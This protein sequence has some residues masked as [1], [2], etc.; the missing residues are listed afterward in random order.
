[1]ANLLWVVLALL[2][3]AGLF[4]LANA[5]EP[6]WCSPDGL[7]F[8]CRV[9]EI[10]ATGRSVSRW[11]DARAEIDGDLVA[12]KRKVLMRSIGSVDARRVAARSDRAPR[13]RAIYLLDGDPLI[14]LRIPDSSRA[15]TRLDALVRS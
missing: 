10:D 13:R 4:W 14:A 5:I 15:V 8:T 1:M 9:Q 7:R 12:I 3:V 6:H 11:Y 2:V